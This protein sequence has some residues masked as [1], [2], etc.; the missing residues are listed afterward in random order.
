MIQPPHNHELGGGA[1][2]STQNEGQ[3]RSHDCR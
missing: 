3:K 2:K 1:K